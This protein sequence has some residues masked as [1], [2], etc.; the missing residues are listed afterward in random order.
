MLRSCTKT[1]LTSTTT[2][3]ARLS[4]R[5]AVEQQRQSQKGGQ[6]LGE[7]YQR[8]ENSIRE[9]YALSHNIEEL[10]TQQPKL[11][12]Q[13]GLKYQKN[14][15]IFRGF[16]VPEKPKPPEPDGAHFPSRKTL[17]NSV[18]D[19]CMS[20]CAI[21]VYD[22]YEDSM[23]TYNKSVVALRTSLEGLG[24]PESEWPPSIQSKSFQNDVKRNRGAN[25]VSLD[26]FEAMELALKTKR[27]GTMSHPRYFLISLSS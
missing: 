7:R 4:S 10:S 3:P 22:L 18:S 9:K 20:G 14:A 1:L 5:L 16:V 11:V 6:N 23:N 8:L 15:Q 21:C 12:S 24:I 17:S 2:Q 27:E 13:K 25:A 26:A 19:C